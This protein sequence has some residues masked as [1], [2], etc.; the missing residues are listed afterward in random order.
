METL[1]RTRPSCRFPPVAITVPK[2]LPRGTTPLGERKVFMYARPAGCATVFMFTL[3]KR[4]H[5]DEWGA[6]SVGP[7]CVSERMAAPQSAVDSPRRTSIGLRKAGSRS[8]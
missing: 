1:G 5:S 7:R 4:V 6:S 3:L 2:L 8:S